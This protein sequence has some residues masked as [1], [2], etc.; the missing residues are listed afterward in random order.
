VQR[1]ALDIIATKISGILCGNANHAD[2][3]AR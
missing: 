3:L 1:E 2:H